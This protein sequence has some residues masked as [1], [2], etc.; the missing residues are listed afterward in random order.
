M[1]AAF[2]DGNGQMI[3]QQHPDPVAAEGDA[4]IQVKATGI[5]GSDLLMNNDKEEA[6]ELPA[7][8]E[9]TGIIVDVG[10]AVDREIVGKRV[11][12]ETIGQGLACSTCWYCRM[13]QYRQCQNKAQAEGGGFAEYIKRKAIGCYEIS[14]SMTWD[15]GALVEPLAVSIHGIRRGMM[16]GGETVAI[17][18]AGT[19]GLTAVVAAKQLGA[20]K[21]FVTARH[22]QQAAM[23]LSLGADYTCSPEGE[24]F[25]NL[26]RSHTNGRGADLAVETV[27]GKSNRTL[28]QSV[29]STRMQGR[30][31][32]LGGFRTPL[33][34]DWL[35]PLLKEQSIIFS[36]CYGILDGYHD[37]EMAINLLSNQSN[38]LSDIVTHTYSLEEIQQGFECAYDKSTGSI[39]VQI[40]QD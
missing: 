37:Y 22:E 25:E 7:G 27:G 24:E 4:I 36:S 3:I 18:G 15:E 19:I 10:A 33:Q 38:S 6:D 34:F 13:G 21:I 23:A 20:G 40:H 8:H 12:I 2:Y 5:C 39:K 11:A 31:V 30:I 26:V 9:V 29:E 35:A 32:I 16:N 1:E 14:G 17:L 28:I